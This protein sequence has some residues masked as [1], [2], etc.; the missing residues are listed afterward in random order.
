[1][2]DSIDYYT[3]ELANINESMEEEQKRKLELA[4]LGSISLQANVWIESQE[5]GMLSEPTLKSPRQSSTYPNGA[6][7]NMTLIGTTQYGS[8]DEQMPPK[9]IKVSDEDEDPKQ[10][11]LLDDSF[12]LV[13]KISITS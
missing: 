8:L 10:W 13:R 7:D 2:A 4:E 12:F 5:Q 11:R 3:R 1:L 6:K 9:T